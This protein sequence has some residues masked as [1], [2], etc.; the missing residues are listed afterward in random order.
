MAEDDLAM[1][2]AGAPISGAY[3]SAMES[4]MEIAEA[5]YRAALEAVPA[6]PAWFA[7]P[8]AIAA[9]VYRGIHNEIRR[10]GYDNLRQRAYTRRIAKGFLAARALRELHR[11]PALA[12]GE[13]IPAVGFGGGGE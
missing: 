5:D 8:V 9:H 3:Q 11:A 12:M 4:L 2:R 1:M 6:L 7:R 10:N 13:A